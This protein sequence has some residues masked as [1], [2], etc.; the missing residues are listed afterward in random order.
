ME[1]VGYVL[2]SIFN[3][4]W[5][6]IYLQAWKRYSAE[7]AFRWGTLDQRDDLLSEPR[8]LFRVNFTSFYIVEHVS[9]LLASFIVHSC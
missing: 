9:N 2:F 6:T 4:V 7:L 8:P 3:V 5:A 1:D